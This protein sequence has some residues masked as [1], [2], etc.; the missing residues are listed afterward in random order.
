MQDRKSPSPLTEQEMYFVRS[1]ISLNNAN[2]AYKLAYPDEVVDKSNRDI[3]AMVAKVMNKPSVRRLIELSK[4][5][6]LD[7]AALVMKET[8]LFGTAADKAKVAIKQFDIDERFKE[9][10]AV[11]RFYDISREIGAVV[12]VPASDVAT[13]IPLVEATIKGNVIWRVPLRRLRKAS[14]EV[15]VPLE[16]RKKS[17]TSKS[18]ATRIVKEEGKMR[19]G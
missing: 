16:G 9:S 3:Q 18:A 10:E 12:E 11:K 1:Y 17:R 7:L 2:G 13:E 5:S 6:S 15:W 19:L 14:G 4:M 8:M